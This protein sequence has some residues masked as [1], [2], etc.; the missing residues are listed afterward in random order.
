MG[1]IDKQVDAGTHVNHLQEIGTIEL[2][3]TVNKGKNNRRMY[4]ILK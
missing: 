1:E 2:T 3:K 4:F